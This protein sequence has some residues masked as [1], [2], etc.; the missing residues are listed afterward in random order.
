MS[1]VTKD[2]REKVHEIQYGSVVLE[3]FMKRD[4]N[5]DKVYYDY[6]TSRTFPVSGNEMGR[7]PYCQQ[8][9][10]RDNIVAL[11]EGMKWVSD[12]HRAIRDS[13]KTEYYSE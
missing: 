4:P 8:R 1:Y 9:D 7:G 11:C 3:F 13:Q 5:S 2:G 12:Q 10:L 6:R